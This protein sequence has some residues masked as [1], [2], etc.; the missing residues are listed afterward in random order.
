MAGATDLRGRVVVAADRVLDRMRL[1]IAVMGAVRPYLAAMYHEAHHDKSKPMPHGPPEFMLQAQ[2]DLHARLTALFEPYADQLAV[3]PETAAVALR[4]LT[5]GS[6][7]PEL[8]LRPT[9]TA[10]QIADLVLDGVRTRRTHG[11]KP[12]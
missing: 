1:T 2:R 8:G 4:S 3:P 12:C 5:F 11:E 7:R 6:A 9:L 10:D